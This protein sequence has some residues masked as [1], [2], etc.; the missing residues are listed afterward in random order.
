MFNLFKLCWHKKKVC[1]DHKLTK[2]YKL[3]L[4]E[5]STLEYRYQIYSHVTSLKI[6]EVM[7]TLS[8]NSPVVTVISL[9]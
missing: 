9:I 1:K 5:N 3:Y 2:N 6:G 7:L 8:W 4:S